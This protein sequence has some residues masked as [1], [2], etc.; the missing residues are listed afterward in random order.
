VWQ[1]VER[2]FGMPG[3]T[4]SALVT[5]VLRRAAK[6]ARNAE[7]AAEYERAYRALPET[8]EERAVHAALVNSTRRRLAELDRVEVSPAGRRRRQHTPDDAR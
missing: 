2:L 3:E 5:R 7:I 1:E 8:D 6:E 4:R